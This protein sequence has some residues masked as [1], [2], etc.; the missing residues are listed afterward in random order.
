MPLEP[1]GKADM[2]LNKNVDDIAKDDIESL[3]A[4]Q[5]PESATIEYKETL[6]L[7]KPEDHKEFVRDV[8][9]FANTRGGMIIFGVSEDRKRGIPHEL[10]GI[11]I[12]NW[13]QLKQRIE[14]LLRDGTNPRIYGLQIPTRPINLGNARFAFV[15][16]IPRSFS[17]PHM[18]VSGGDCRFYYRTNAGRDRLDVSG[19]RTLFAMA[20]TAATQTRAFRADRLAKIQGGDTPEPLFQGPKFVLHM[21]PSDAFDMRSHHDLSRFIDCPEEMPNI[22]NWSVSSGTSRSRYN[23]DGVVGYVG[24]YEK[25]DPTYWY[26][27]YFRN[28]IIEAVDVQYNPANHGHAEELIVTQYEHGVLSAM[29]RFMEIQRDM[30]AAPPI[31]ALLTLLG[32]KGRSLS[33][34]DRNMPNITRTFAG[35][36]TFREE[37]LVLPEVVLEDFECNV[38][39]EMEPIFEIVWNAA[40]LSRTAESRPSE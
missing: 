16:R 34:R 4:N 29:T 20:D 21:V 33:Y 19:L 2:T 31:F 12:A 15:I 22:G 14:N 11:P 3:V 18:V 5:V 27:Q 26:T 17:S 13:D 35:G 1:L 23:L 6:S 25:A 28:G 9:A 8:S 30:G 10:C 38:S 36:E 32:V 24:R 39:K 7:D 40:G 37:H